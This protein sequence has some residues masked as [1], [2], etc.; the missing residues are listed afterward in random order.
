M[1]TLPNYQVSSRVM[2]RPGDRFRVSGGPYWRTAA[3]ERIPLSV[4]GACR[5]V[6]VYRERRRVWLLVQARDG[7]AILHVEGR[8][9]NRMMPELVCRPYKIRGKI[10]AIAKA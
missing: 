1:E 4:R 7:M 6:S 8:R 10:R 9:R 5:L 3:G 2:L